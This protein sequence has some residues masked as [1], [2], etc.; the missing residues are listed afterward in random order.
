MGLAIEEIRKHAKKLGINSVSKIKDKEAL[1]HAIQLAEGNTDCFNKIPDC[2]LNNC[3][4]FGDC[5]KKN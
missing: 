2:T 3:F 4:W 5:I 1:I